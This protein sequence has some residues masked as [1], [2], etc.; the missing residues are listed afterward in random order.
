MYPMKTF[1]IEFTVG[2]ATDGYAATQLILATSRTT[3][4]A[5]LHAVVVGN[6]RDAS[7]AIKKAWRVG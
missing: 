6:L 5:Q 1:E 7:V 4:C 3:A 2:T